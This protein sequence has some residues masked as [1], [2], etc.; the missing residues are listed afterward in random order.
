[1]DERFW[2]RDCLF[3]GL[4]LDGLRG[5]DRHIV[6]DIA[7][8]P[9]SREFDPLIGGLGGRRVV[10]GVDWGHPVDDRN[11]SCVD[12]DTDMDESCEQLLHGLVPFGEGANRDVAIGRGRRSGQP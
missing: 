9:T 8:A 7:K 3:C 6:E 4:D 5:G 12:T 11:D 10:I 1:M 2:A